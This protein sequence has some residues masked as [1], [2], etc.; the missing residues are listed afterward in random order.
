[1]V[2]VALV[3]GGGREW[4]EG[5]GVR[6]LVLNILSPS[7]LLYVHKYCCLCSYIYELGYYK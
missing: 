5:R 2:V 6:H 7:F 4:W 3:L 1:M